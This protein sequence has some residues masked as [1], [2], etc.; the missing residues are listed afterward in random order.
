MSDMLPPPIQFQGNQDGP[1][2]K[3]LA[4]PLVSEIPGSHTSPGSSA[5][6]EPIAQSLL[7]IRLLLRLPMLPPVA[8]HLR[9]PRSMQ[10]KPLVLVPSHQGVRENAVA[11]RLGLVVA[12]PLAGPVGLVTGFVASY[13]PFPDFF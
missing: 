12:V 4:R 8:R 6:L 9:G 7:A 10:S 5:A 3:S 1:G 11:M 2:A 13:A